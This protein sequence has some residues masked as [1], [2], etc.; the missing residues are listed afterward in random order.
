M[1]HKPRKG[2]NCFVYVA[3]SCPV[4]FLALLIECQVCEG[5]AIADSRRG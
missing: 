5:N 1:Q 2:V 4:G 3:K